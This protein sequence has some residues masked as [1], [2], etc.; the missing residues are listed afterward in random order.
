MRI[1]H[2]REF[3]DLAE[4]LNFTL[5]A[6]RQNISQPVL[7]THIKSIENELGVKLF[8]RD[9][10]SV[11]LTR[12]G[13]LFYEEAVQI[14]SRYDRALLTIERAEKGGGDSLSVG[15]LHYAFGSIVPAA[16]N[17]FSDLYPQTRI[18]TAVYGYKDIT[19]A[20]L[21]N[22]VDA[23]LTLDVDERVHRYCKSLK[24]GEDPIRLMVNEKHPLAQQQVV[25]ISDLKD[26]QFILPHPHFSDVFPWFYSTLFERAGFTPRAAKY[27]CNADARLRCVQQNMGVALVGG[28]L[29]RANIEGTAFV[30]IAED[31]CCYDLVAMWRKDAR[32]LAVDDFIE[33]AYSLRRDLPGNH[34]WKN[35]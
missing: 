17:M 27:Y 4:C 20:L 3:V 2:I 23:A 14:I 34:P 32:N 26:E 25:S 30:D 29:R 1:E 22:A 8:D 21:D 11:N 12:S 6:R 7:S 33:I 15:Y 9:H 18:R 28:H 10:H 5:T 19:Q 13:R 31:W 35:N 24:L 16:V